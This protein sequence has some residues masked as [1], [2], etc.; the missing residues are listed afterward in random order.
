MKWAG[1][2]RALILAIVCGL[3]ISGLLSNRAQAAGAFPNETSSGSVGIQGTISSAAPTRGATI[4]TPGN[5]ASFTT[6][7]ITVTGLCPTGLL[8]KLFSNNIFVGSVFCASGSYSLQISLF[9]G[10]NN[11]VA[12]VYDSLD[13]AGPDSNTVTVTFNS[14]LFAEFGTQITLSSNYAERGAP[15]GQELDWPIELNG[16]TG[17]YAVSIDWGDGSPTT[18]ISQSTTGEITIKHTYKTAGIYK[19]II[20]ATDKNGDTAFL[21]VVGQATGAA[22]NNSKGG[23]GN[24]LV[25]VEVLWWPAILMVPLIVAAFWVGRRHELFSL[26]KQLEKTRDKE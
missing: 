1:A 25:R 2:R 8:V 24:A 19:I 12:R 23:S 15:P 4:A 13:Q 3:V 11:L 6:L 16:G 5:G 7:P 10:Q 26:R 14:A 20:K 18:L 22:Q 21:Q 17:P 9:S